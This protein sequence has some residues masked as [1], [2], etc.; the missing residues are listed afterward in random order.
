ML[1]ST[2]DATAGSN[3]DDNEDN[4]NKGEDEEE[5]NE[6]Q[7]QQQQRWQ[8]QRCQGR[9]SFEQ[10]CCQA[11]IW[12]TSRSASC[13]WT[14]VLMLT[15]YY[16][17]WAAR[18]TSSPEIIF[19]L[20]LL[21]CYHYWVCCQNETL[22]L[23]E[24]REFLGKIGIFLLLNSNFPHTK[25]D[26]LQR[27]SDFLQRLSPFFDGFP[28]F[29]NSFPLSAESEKIYLRR[30]VYKRSLFDLRISCHSSFVIPAN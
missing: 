16:H 28:I 20:W 10:Y 24:T 25:F 6:Q 1:I 21:F 7:R 27:L 9:Q 8:W 2:W 17:R 14:S 12:P 29:F 4:N 23:Q 15:H 26:F 22:K 13:A 5:V 30:Q 18:I 11:T 3:K 19:N